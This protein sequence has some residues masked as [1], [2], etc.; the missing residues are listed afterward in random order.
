MRKWIAL[1]AA[2]SV[3][4]WPAASS[5]AGFNIQVDNFYVDGGIATTVM[6]VTNETGADAR[7]VFIDCVFLDKDHK[8]IDIGKALI[9]AIPAGGHAYDKA[10]AV[11][12]DRV[13]FADCSVVKHN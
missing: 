11:T 1:T 2:I 4:L 3:A 10:S 7:S 13:Q 6:K 12:G 5:A 9:S 8:A